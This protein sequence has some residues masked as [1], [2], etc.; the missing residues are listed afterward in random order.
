ML[1]KMAFH[2]KYMKE[3]I[4][5]GRFARMALPARFL[6]SPDPRQNPRDHRFPQSLGIVI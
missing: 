1:V 3:K 6:P 2:W 4:R 5:C